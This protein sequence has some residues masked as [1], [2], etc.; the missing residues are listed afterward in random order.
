MTDPLQALTPDPTND[1]PSPDFAATLRRRVSAI[2]ARADRAIRA[3][4][5]LAQLNL[6]L[7]Q[8]PLDAPE[9]APFVAALDRINAIADASPGFIW[10]LTDDDGGPS[11]NVEVPGADDPLLAS[12]LSVWTDL[13][14]LRDFMYRSDHFSYLRRRDEW[15]QRERQPMTVGWWIPAG[16][17]PSLDDALERLERLRTDGPSDQAFPLGRTIPPAPTH[18]PDQETSMTTIQ[19]TNSP[20]TSTQLL[21]PYL[22]VGDSRA[23]LLF[24]GEVFGASQSGELFEMDDGRIGHAEMTIGDH[25]FYMADEF[26]EMKL[27]SPANAGTNSVSIVIHV[28]D[29][30]AVYAHALEAGATGERAP[31]NQHGFRSGWFVDPWG[32]RWSPTSAE[33]PGVV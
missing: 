24:Y 18:P 13:E 9:M 15:F 19:A 32:H 11:S 31:A 1:G 26:S 3:Q 27:A 4:W 7:F 20:T 5:H 22:T 23:A 14:S 6:G 25:V 12:N 21:I 30:D 29:A 2:E 28:D 10:R 33:K 16:T 8:Y 17:L